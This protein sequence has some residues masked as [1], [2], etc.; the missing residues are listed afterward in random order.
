MK[1]LIV[2]AEVSPFA[3]VGGLADVAGSLPKDL[4]LLGHDVRVAMPSY[5]MV[6][7]NEKYAV[8]TIQE[9]IAVPIGPD[10]EQAFV[11]L[12]HI[13]ESIP[14]YLIGGPNFFRES[15]E[16]S[17]VYVSGWRPYAFFCRAVLES[18]KRIGWIPDVI[19][20]NDWHTGLLPAYLH[21]GA[22]GRE[23]D[24]TSKVFTIHNLAYQGEFDRDILPQAGLPDYLYSME[25]LECYGRINL[26]KAGAVFSDIVNTVS[27]KY[28]DEIQTCEFGCRLEGLLK[29]L[30]S[31]GR[32][33]GILNGIDYSV[34]DPSSDSRIAKHY[35]AESPEGKADNKAAL[36]KQLGLPVRSDVPVFGLV[37]R[38][39]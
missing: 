12:T 21:I 15:S 4:A 29:Y 2:A 24:S 30:H 28:A 27:E 38:L 25:G 19:H 20:C 39:A 26:L 34:F 9:N 17:K 35:C 13:G 11:K 5:P 33:R 7:D 1:I 6:E 3:K 10:T 31:Q 22:A 16:S 37:S 36:Q 14:V 8:K 18:M 23:F 32:L